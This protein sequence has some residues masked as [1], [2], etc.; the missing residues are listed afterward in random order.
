M[1]PTETDLRRRGSPDQYRSANRPG[2]DSRRTGAQAIYHTRCAARRCPAISGRGQRASRNQRHPQVLARPHRGLIF[3]VK[4]EVRRQVKR[5]SSASSK[6]IF[7]TGASITLRCPDH[8]VFD[9]CRGEGEGAR[10]ADRRRQGGAAHQRSAGGDSFAGRDGARRRPRDSQNLPRL[11][12]INQDSYEIVRYG[13]YDERIIDR[14]LLR[15]TILLVCSGKYLPLPD[16][17]RRSRKK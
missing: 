3:E 1:L 6:T 9:G 13:V 10:R 8:R 11:C 16:E 2:P 4:E 17:P 14:G 15:T 5:R 12:K 7:T